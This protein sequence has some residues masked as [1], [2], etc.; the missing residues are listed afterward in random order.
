MYVKRGFLTD[1]EPPSIM[2]VR[3]SVT[4]QANTINSN[5]VNDDL[6]QGPSKERAR[7]ALFRDSEPEWQILHAYCE[8]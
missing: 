7:T 5:L 3:R 1:T 6:Q 4:I 8:V 2:S